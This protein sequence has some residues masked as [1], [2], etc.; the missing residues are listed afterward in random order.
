LLARDRDCIHLCMHVTGQALV[1][2]PRLGLFSDALQRAFSLADTR[3]K[4]VRVVQ[5]GN[6]P[7]L[8]IDQDSGRGVIDCESTSYDSSTDSLC[9]FLESHRGGGACQQTRQW[10]T[11]FAPHSLAWPCHFVHP[12][13]ELFGAGAV[14]WRACILEAFCSLGKRA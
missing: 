8:L 1:G 9:S 10:G 14:T 7:S 11:A 5:A 12:Y 3:H 6:R 13:L 4:T 2:W